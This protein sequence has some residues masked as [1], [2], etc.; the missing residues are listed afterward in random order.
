MSVA[1]DWSCTIVIYIVTQN[2]QCIVQKCDLYW[3]T[4]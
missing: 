4:W 2:D 3:Y 1:I